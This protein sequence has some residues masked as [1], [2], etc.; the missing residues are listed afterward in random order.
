MGSDKVGEVGEPGFAFGLGFRAEHPWSQVLLDNLLVPVFQLHRTAPSAVFTMSADLLPACSLANAT[1]AIAN[2]M[3]ALIFIIVSRLHA[4]FLVVAVLSFLHALVA[5]VVIPH[6][7][8][9]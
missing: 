4:F 3:T 5:V 7:Q 6:F 8:Q 9:H 2:I 1:C